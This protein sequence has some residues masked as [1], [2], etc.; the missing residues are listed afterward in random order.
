MGDKRPWVAYVGPFPY[1]EGAAASRRVLGV[2][3]SLS[4]AGLDV[5]IA[6]GAGESSQDEGRVVAQQDGIV[7]C[8]LNERVA[9]NWPRALRRLRYAWMGGRTVDWLASQPT[10]PKAVILYS[11]Y[12]PYL[13]RLLPWCKGNNVRLIFDAVEWYEPAR[14]WG[15]LTSPYQW[16]I[17]WAMRRLVPQVDG[18]IAISR[19]LADYYHDLG[20]QVA[21]VPPTTS[22]IALHDWQ[23]S[24]QL[25]LCYAGN[26]GTKDDLGAVLRAVANLVVQGASIHLTVAGPDAA[27]VMSMLGGPSGQQL[28]WLSTPGMLNHDD[29]QKVVGGADF[30]VFT[31]RKGRLSQ[32]GFP[33]KFVE[34]FASGTPVIANLTSDMHLHLREGLTGFVCERPDSVGIASALSRALGLDE[35]AMRS[36]RE[37]CISQAWGAFH[38]AGYVDAL[39]DLVDVGIST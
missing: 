2:A 19:Y 28:P 27:Q 11:G 5:V 1:P 29:V 22:T 9:E 39:R 24:R 34:S 36:M 4:L 23:P 6:S 37:A 33:T 18:V 35:A 16:N 10:R 38:P 31:R 25:R 17:E 26:P 13:Q 15:Y 20:L 12:S 21:V 8:H 32:A 7:Y 14:P 3:E 30:S